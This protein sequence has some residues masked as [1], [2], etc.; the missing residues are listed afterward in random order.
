[1]TL[2]VNF[3]LRLV[4]CS[5]ASTSG[6]DQLQTNHLKTWLAVY[7][8]SYICKHKLLPKWQAPGHFIYSRATHASCMGFAHRRTLPFPSW[9]ILQVHTQGAVHGLPGYPCLQ[10]VLKAAVFAVAVHPPAQ[11]CYQRD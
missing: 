7:S 11:A 4:A 6:D 5:L 9:N 3:W 2:L 10:R 8:N 1:L